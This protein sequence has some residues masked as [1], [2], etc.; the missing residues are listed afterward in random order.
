VSPRLGQAQIVIHDPPGLVEAKIRLL[1]VHPVSDHPATDAVD[2]PHRF[3]VLHLV[4]QS[5]MRQVMASTTIR[6]V[7][8]DEVARDRAAADVDAPVGLCESK[9]GGNA[10]VPALRFGEEIDPYLIERSA[11]Q[12]GAV[13]GI[14]LAP[15]RDPRFAD[16]RSSSRNDDFSTPSTPVGRRTRADRAGR[17]RRTVR[18]DISA[19]R[20]TVGAAAASGECDTRPHCKATHG[21]TPC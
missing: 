20:G 10:V 6:V 11:H 15:H 2:D 9:D 21:R 14:S 12:S 8:E 4:D 7:E 3:V 16:H 13:V 5:N 17:W 19:R 1:E 18:S